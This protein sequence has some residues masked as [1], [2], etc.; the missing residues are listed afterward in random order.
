MTSNF[1]VGYFSFRRGSAADVLRHSSN[2]GLDR[3]PCRHVLP[4]P[5]RSMRSS[6]LR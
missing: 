6:S 1:N 5:A 3:L 2:L 4:R